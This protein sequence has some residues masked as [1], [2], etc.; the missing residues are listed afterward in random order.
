MLT[1]NEIMQAIV[2]S[3][4]YVTIPAT[5]TTKQDA[6]EQFTAHVTLNVSVASNCTLEQLLERAAKPV[7]IDYANNKRSK[8]L[9]ALKAIDGKTIELQITPTNQR[10]EAIPTIDKAMNVIAQQVKAGKLTLEQAIA[11]LSK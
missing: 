9:E 3:E 4:T 2:A 7:V 8:G 6:A 11:M 1:N 5:I 10:A